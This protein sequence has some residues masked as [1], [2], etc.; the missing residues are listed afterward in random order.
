[1]SSTQRLRDLFAD[2]AWDW[3][4]ERIRKALEL[5]HPLPVRFV[6][7]DPSDAERRAA[8]SLMGRSL[9]A[10]KSRSLSLPRDEL[11]ARL[12]AAGL[13]EELREICEAVEGP[14]HPRAALRRERQAAWEALRA[15][16]PH[17]PAD[18]EGFFQGLRRLANQTPAT[19]AALLAN[20]D[21]LLRELCAEDQLPTR[22]AARLFGDSHALDSDR[23][24]TRLLALH[25][26]HPPGDT[27][28]L[29]ARMGLTPDEVSS[30][31]LTLG[32]RFAGG[33]ALAQAA[34]LLAEARIPHRMLLRHFRTVLEPV[35]GAV[36]VCENPAVLEAA[37]ETAFPEAMVCTEGQPSHACLRLL[38]ACATAG[39]PLK[40][41]ADF[42]AAGVQIVHLL[43][44]RYPEAGLWAYDA[45]SYVA[46]APGP[47]L[48][49]PVPA[50]PWEP[51]LCGAINARGVAV[52][53]EQLLPQLLQ[54]EKGGDRGDR[55]GRG[56]VYR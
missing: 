18:A 40:V 32:L 26:N 56:K 2:P 15:D 37:V 52:H 7:K 42:D 4:R 13:C 46:A 25:V 28:G 51:G 3:L 1:M 45:A 50:T 12:R 8:H 53:E 9:Q 29:W 31:V 11:L 10:P 22:A 20:L 14:I 55:G 35:A 43:L 41:R 39:I 49:S 33:H 44:R 34:T 5:D 23:P 17:V 16:W 27:R 54:L 21:R 30:T 47:E 24:L 36:Y 19:G 6:R 38:D 48:V